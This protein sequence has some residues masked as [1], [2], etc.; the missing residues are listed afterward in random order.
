[1]VTI[2]VS[3]LGSGHVTRQLGLIHELLELGVRIRLL[4]TREQFE[5]LQSD[6]LSYGPIEVRF[7]PE[8]PLFRISSNDSVDID[9]TALS[10]SKVLDMMNRSSYQDEWIGLLKGSD[11]VINDIESVHN[12]VCVSMGIPIVNI[13]NF[14][15]S[16]LLFSV[17]LEHLGNEYLELESLADLNLRLP[18]TT[19]C[20]SFERRGYTDVGL[21]CRPIDFES[22]V[23]VPKPYAVFLLGNISSRIDV[24]GICRR[25]SSKGL[26][27]VALGSQVEGT[28]SFPS[29]LPHVQNLIGQSSVVIG[30][31]GYSTVAETY[32]AGVPFIH[33]VRGGF[34]EDQVISEQILSDKRG[35]LVEF[36]TRGEKIAETMLEFAGKKFPCVPNGSRFIAQKVL[37]LL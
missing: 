11:M 9:G 35:E 16:D 15:W 4:C 7:L 25:L 36:G 19:G 23:P 5:R 37:N 12:P 34:F 2:V 28:L 26:T 10:F 20:K 27:S 31:I 21:L 33:F 6:I 18:F 1:M 29:G 14:T 22:K 17:G 32:C 24:E 13:S 3:P 30:K 8:V